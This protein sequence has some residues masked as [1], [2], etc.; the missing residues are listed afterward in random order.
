M[1]NQISTEST[2]F[3]ANGCR[4]GNFVLKN[5]SRIYDISRVITS[6]HR[7]I[8]FYHI[9]TD[10]YLIGTVLYLIGT[11]LYLDFRQSL[12]SWAQD[13]TSKIEVKVRA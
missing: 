5:R 7:G 4:I 13:F 2:E 3:Q 12:L 8:L 6:K 11:H 10:I 9:D 1:F